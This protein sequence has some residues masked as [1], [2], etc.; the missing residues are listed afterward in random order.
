MKEVF[1]I[2]FCHICIHAHH[3]N[4]AFPHPRTI[5][6][7]D[8]SL[9]IKLIAEYLCI[10]TDHLET[11]IDALWLDNERK[12]IITLNNLHRMTSIGK[13]LI[14]PFFIATFT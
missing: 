11:H 1:Y 4:E 3:P 6:Y 9:S 13:L 8:K 12:L 10:H 7:F 2:F 5:R 14:N